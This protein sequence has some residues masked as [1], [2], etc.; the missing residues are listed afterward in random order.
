MMRFKN[1]DIVR[2]IRACE[3]YKDQ[4]GSEWM[5]EQYDDLVN[6]LK[7]YRDQYSVDGEKI[8]WA[9]PESSLFEYSLGGK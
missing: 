2:L 4:T 6:K 1:E 8:P 3:L 5:W 9:H 7:V